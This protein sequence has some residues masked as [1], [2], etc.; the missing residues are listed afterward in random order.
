MVFGIWEMYHRINPQKNTSVELEL[1]WIGTRLK[2][3]ENCKLVSGLIGI[4]HYS[5]PQTNAKFCGVLF[6]TAVS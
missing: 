6:L 2:V 5:L 3:G 1:S 4:V